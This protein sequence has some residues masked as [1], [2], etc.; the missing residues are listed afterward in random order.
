[1]ELSKEEKQFYA[2]HLLLPEI[3]EEGQK[4][5][6]A[7]K[8][9]VV[10][11]GGLGSPLLRYLASAGIGNL[12]LID[13]DVVETSNLQRQILFCP[14]DEGRFKA[15]TA[16]DRLEA[17]NPYIKIKAYNQR[18]THKN[19]EHIFKDY[20]CIADGTDNFATRYLINDACVLYGKTLVFGSLNKFE[21]H[22]SVFNYC[23]DGK[24]GP[25][26]RDI[27]PDPPIQG[28]IPSCS[29]IG[30]V[31]AVAGTVATL[32]A[33]E[34]IKVCLHWDDILSGKFLI[35]DLLSMNFRK[36]TI[37]NSNSRKLIHQLPSETDIPCQIK[38]NSIV[39]QQQLKEKIAQN[40]DLVLIDV[41]PEEEH[42]A[43]NIGG[44]N[45]PLAKIE[46]ALDSIPRDKE[47]IL[48]CSVGKRSARAV[49]ILQLNGYATVFNLDQGLL[50]WQ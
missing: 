38:T 47:V 40:L 14:G 4:L 18:L 27:Y 8:V 1:M 17:C 28:S 44:I 13:C 22:V 19:I 26:Y 3:G 9:L 39:T 37:P 20:D 41:R 33:M 31:G 12:G 32:Q 6:K 46:N 36:V 7:S 2:R 43:F 24:Y 10:G 30:I 42:R 34:V 25:N 23:K 48:Y 11:T 5:L 49:Q 35:V 21:G 50:G 45:I 16:K 15:V 29:E